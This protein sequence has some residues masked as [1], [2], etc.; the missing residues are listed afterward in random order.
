[1]KYQ[2]KIYTLLLIVLSYMAQGQGCSDAGFCTMGAMKPDQAFHKKVDIKLKSIEL[3]QYV[4]TTRFG[5]VV[6]AYTADV[7]VALGN[8]TAIQGKLPYMLV[9]GELA[10][11][12]GVGDVS[13]SLTQ[14][15]V[16]KPSYQ[17]NLTL[18]T[19]IPTGKATK[20]SNDGRPLPMYYQSTL[21]TYDLILG[22]SVISKK[23]LFA[24]GIQHP[25][26]EIKNGFKWGAWTDSDL[27]E[28]ANQYP[29]SQFLKRGTDVM[30]RLERNFRFSRFNVNIGL[31]P[32]YRLNQDVITAPKTGERVESVDS[33]GL[34]LSAILGM[35]YR[36]STR[37]ALKFVLGA[38]LIRRAKNP[39]GLSR[40][41]VNTI[42]YQFNF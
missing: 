22:A 4:A 24:V 32:I 2:A 11:T 38:R 39:D 8:K 28:K 12:N 35:G 3:S 10:N 7:S 16:K 42:G 30:L 41:L 23:W 17:F 20:L 6:L 27:T 5:D 21:G 19:K 9:Y 14:S 29:V 37:S 25:F 15:I 1:M 40:E 33:N 18:G 31:L 13:F 34:A 36:F 26:N